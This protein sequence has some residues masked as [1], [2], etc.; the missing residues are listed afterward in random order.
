MSRAGLR[1]EEWAGSCAVLLEKP[2]NCRTRE[3][4]AARGIYGARLTRD[5]GFKNPVLCKTQLRESTQIN[6][7]HSCFVIPLLLTAELP[8]RKAELAAGQESVLPSILKS[9]FPG[10]CQP[11]LSLGSCLR[12]ECGATAVQDV[13]TA[14]SC[15][16]RGSCRTP[17]LY[18][19]LEGRRKARCSCPSH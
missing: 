2:P 6:P 11:E 16:P 14:L 10:Q 8:Q 1:K 19:M 3:P 7:F 9:S 13:A 17:N 18:F 12:G 4:Q 5:N 15:S